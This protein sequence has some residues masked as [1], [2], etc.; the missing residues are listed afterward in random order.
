MP[1]HH[2]RRPHG[3]RVRRRSPHRPGRPLGEALDESRPTLLKTDIEGSE[4]ELLPGLR[5]LPSQMRAV[6]IELHL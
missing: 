1:K 5:R 2:R 6:A 3:T 4:Y